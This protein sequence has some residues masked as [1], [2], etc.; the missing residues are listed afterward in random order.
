MIN[1]MKLCGLNVAAVHIKIGA[2]TNT[3][4]ER[5]RKTSKDQLT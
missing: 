2:Q 1:K 3:F 5:K 4:I